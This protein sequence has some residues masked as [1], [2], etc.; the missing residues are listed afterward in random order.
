MNRGNRIQRGTRRR[1][2]G[3]DYIKKGDYMTRIATVRDIIKKKIEKKSRGRIG[4]K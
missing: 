1:Q 2:E 3:A 4:Q